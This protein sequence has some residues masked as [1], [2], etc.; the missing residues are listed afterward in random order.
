MS[1]NSLIPSSRIEELEAR[2]ITVAL[3]AAIGL[4]IADNIW[5]FLDNQNWMF[6]LILLVLL[7]LLRW[8]EVTRKKVI[9]VSEGTPL[10][11]YTSYSEFYGEALQTVSKS[12]H[13]V[14]AV[15]SHTSAPSQHT[16]ASR[17]YY[18]G[19]ITWA[20]RSPGQRSLHRVI[21]VPTESPHVQAWVDEQND[22]AS[23]IENYHVKVLR[24][25]QGMAVEGENFAVI[26]SE[27]VFLGFA[28]NDRDELNGFSIRDR[29]V[30]SAFEQHFRELWRVA[31]DESESPPATESAFT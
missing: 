2:A 16:A 17:R 5:K 25:P 29:R 20:R 19:T 24:Y 27:I 23:R 13:T 10:R 15:F 18:K 22:L 28:M 8:L 6:P 4:S 3:V 30:A 9:A 7:I 21:R 14:Y 26:D 12:T 31:E 11:I 1:M